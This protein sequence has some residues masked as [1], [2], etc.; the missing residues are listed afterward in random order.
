MKDE[1]ARARV[2]EVVKQIPRGKVAS[3]KAVAQLVGIHPRQVGRVLHSNT[4][5][6]M[7]PCHRV[8][9]SDGTTASGYAFGGPGIQQERLEKEGVEFKHNSV[10]LDKFFF[11]IFDKK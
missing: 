2:F 10:S 1:Q 9:H 7:Y 11:S 6:E 4:N 5:Q 3:Y 8:V